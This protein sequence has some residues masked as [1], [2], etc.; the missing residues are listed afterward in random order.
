VSQYL[1]CF[2]LGQR[3][4][5]E[6]MKN[7]DI[8]FPYL[9]T[10]MQTVQAMS[11]DE[12]GIYISKERHVTALR[13]KY[14]DRGTAACRRRLPAFADRRVLRSQRGASLAVVISIFWTGASTFSFK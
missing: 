5:T 4:K 6:N 12:S 14:T 8:T 9:K 11:V 7:S 13:A 2:L 10:G 3:Q 1:G